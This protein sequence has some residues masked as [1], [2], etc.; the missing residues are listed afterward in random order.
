MPIIYAAA[1]ILVSAAGCVVCVVVPQLRRY[2]LRALFIPLS[3]GFFSVT[4]MFLSAATASLFHEAFSLPGGPAVRGTRGAVI[5]ALVYIIS[6]VV[7]AWLTLFF[8]RVL[9]RRFG[10]P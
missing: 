2:S 8:I 4:G 3:F 6:G 1:F 9:E 5:G 10:F 7:G